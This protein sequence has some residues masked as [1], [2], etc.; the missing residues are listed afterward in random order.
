M[1]FFQVERLRSQTTPINLD[2]IGSLK[3]GAKDELSSSLTSTASNSTLT[4]Q[5]D[6]D[7]PMKRTFTISEMK[8]PPS[9]SRQKRYD[10]PVYNGQTWDKQK[11]LLYRGGLYNYTVCSLL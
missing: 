1:I 4:E 7:N 2:I 10:E 5:P 8:R 3:G 9:I 11:W 6:E